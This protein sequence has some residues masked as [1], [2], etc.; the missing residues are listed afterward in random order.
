[1]NGFLLKSQ[2]IMHKA[3]LYSLYVCTHTV[4]GHL[5]TCLSFCSNCVGC[6]MEGSPLSAQK[7]DVSLKQPQGA[8][9]AEAWRSLMQHCNSRAITLCDAN[10][11]AVV[12]SDFFEIIRLLNYSA[13]LFKDSALYFLASTAG[14][15][16]MEVYKGS[17]KALDA[18]LFVIYLTS[19]LMGTIITVQDLV[20]ALFHRRDRGASEVFER[21]DKE[22]K[23]CRSV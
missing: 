3:L 19:E 4:R 13:P 14:P 5:T 20:K 6:H 15:E 8:S 18:S 23:V 1:M 10:Q 9:P 17:G 12:V 21:V 7:L 11:I 22:F 16:Q 2:Q